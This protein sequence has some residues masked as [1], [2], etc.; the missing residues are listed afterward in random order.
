MMAPGPSK[1]LTTIGNLMALD[2]AAFLDHDATAWRGYERLAELTDEDLAGE[3]AGAHGWSGRDLI[4]HMVAWQE[5]A[6][7]VAQEIAVGH[8]SPTQLRS[9]ADWA[10]RGDAVNEDI[11]HTWRALPMAEVRRRMR[12]ASEDLRRLL[13]VVPEG[14]WF[15][16]SERL[17]FFRVRMIDH[18]EAHRDD[19]EAV[20]AAT[21]D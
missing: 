9:D 5:N 14:R 2:P 10:V 15:T 4:A 3:V 11:T 19:L 8:V 21:T 1:Q 18:Y 12:L 17:R 6:L 13:A 7:A 16:D 20:L